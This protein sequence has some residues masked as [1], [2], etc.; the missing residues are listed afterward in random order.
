MTVYVGD[1]KISSRNRLGRS[2]LITF[3]EAWGKLEP[4]LVVGS[5][6]EHMKITLAA[7]KESH[8][9]FQFGDWNELARDLEDTT[10]PTKDGGLSRKNKFYKEGGENNNLAPVVFQSKVPQ[11]SIGWENVDFFQ[12][13]G[14]KRHPNN[15][16]ESVSSKLL[17]EGARAEEPELKKAALDGL[18]RRAEQEYLM[19]NM[20]K[21]PLF[22]AARIANEC[23][24]GI[25]VRG[26][27]LL[28][29]M[30]IESG[31]PTKSQEFKNKTSKEIDLWLCDELEAKE[32]GAVVHFDPRVGWTSR[33]AALLSRSA[34]KRNHQVK[35]TE[36]DWR[37]K[38]EHIKSKRSKELPKLTMPPEEVL[39][40]AFFSRLSEYLEEDYDYRWGHYAPY[41]DLVGPYIRVK[42]RPSEN[43]YGDH[44]LFVFT[45]PN[46]YGVIIRDESRIARAQTALQES[47]A[48]QAQHGGIWYW[49]PGTSFNENIRRVIMSAHSPP[50]GEPL[51]YIR[52]Q[53]LITAAFY[54]PGSSYA[55]QL[56][57]VWDC[58]ATKWQE[59]THSGRLL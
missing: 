36:S 35:G 14:H 50:N 25:A 3:K 32:L 58:Q 12:N 27:G 43:M 44:D 7:Y 21:G 4:L 15:F 16:P 48:F 53:N 57:S 26:T 1:Q 37:R 17:Q 59:S 9:E 30:G 41:T 29:H 40:K 49:K 45:E 55:D 11:K 52:P 42:L 24:V 19:Q 47:Q 46:F 33:Q 13:L 38:L 5:N 54:I 34:C 51:V 6:K 31:A 22:D 20:A 2:R 39:K 23:K 18:R 10:K 56:L 28:A 8:H